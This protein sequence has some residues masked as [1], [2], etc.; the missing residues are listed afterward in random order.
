MTDLRPGA[1]SSRTVLV[2]WRAGT[3]VL[4]WRTEGA[5]DSARVVRGP[6]FTASAEEFPPGTRL[7]VTA[8]IELPGE[9]LAGEEVPS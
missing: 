7:T 1:E 3:G 6:G 2:S 8:E 5:A 4:Y 9:R